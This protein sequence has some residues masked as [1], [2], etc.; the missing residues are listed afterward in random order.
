MSTFSI[1]YLIAF[2]ILCYSEDLF[3]EK[4][5]SPNDWQPAKM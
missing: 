5:L 1:W 3:S 2:T 4:K